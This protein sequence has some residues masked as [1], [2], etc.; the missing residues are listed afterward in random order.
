MAGIYFYMTS[1]IKRNKRRTSNEMNAAK[2]A[3]YNMLSVENPMTLRQLFYRLVSDGTIGKKETEYKSLANLT[4]NM[5]MNGELP[6]EWFADNTRWQRKPQSYSSLGRGVEIFA[7]AY[8]RD[9]W[10]NQGNYVEI[11]LEKDALA[12]VV[13]GVTAEFDV[14]LM[15]SRGYSSLS[16]LHGAAMQIDSIDK[17]TYIYYFGDYDPSGRDIPRDIETKLRIFAPDADI[18]FEIVGVTPEQ[19]EILDLQTR[20]TKKTDT[21]CK[22]FEGELVEVDAIPPKILRAMVKEV[23]EK[24]IDEHQLYQSKLVE[25]QE[26][27]VMMNVAKVFRGDGAA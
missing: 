8:R 27:E 22:N 1:P 17:P 16:Y 14:P 24:H 12:G 18:N 4:K 25:R 2:A 13:Y 26:R 7:E 15:V 19:I 5:R 6:F 23:I 20:P 3:I 21:R 10:I 11:W 9:I